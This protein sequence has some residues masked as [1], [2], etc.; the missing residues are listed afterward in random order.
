MRLAFVIHKFTSVFQ[1]N[2]MLKNDYFTIKLT[3][4]IYVND[5]RYCCG[6]TEVTSDWGNM[7]ETHEL[8][9][10]LDNISIFIY[11][12]LHV[13]LCWEKPFTRSKHYMSKPSFRILTNWSFFLHQH[14]H[15]LSE[16]LFVLTNYSLI[17]ASLQLLLT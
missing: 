10:I 6:C 8:L 12:Q 5:L 11:K 7:N 3:K 4:W 15:T 13:I 17:S 1:W 14:I 9:Q 16:V 2:Q